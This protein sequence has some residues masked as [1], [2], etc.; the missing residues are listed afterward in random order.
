[1]VECGTLDDPT[2]GMVTVSTTIYNSVATYSCNIGH[3]LTGNDMR[4]CLETGSWSSSEPTC[5][6]EFY[7][8]R[9]PLAYIQHKLCQKYNPHNSIQVLKST[10]V[11]NPRRN[12]CSAVLEKNCLLAEYRIAYRIQT[13]YHNYYCC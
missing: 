6:C 13:M 10:K 2:N 9:E 11:Q 4:M 8:F 7:C 1:M 5:T 12:T 3:N